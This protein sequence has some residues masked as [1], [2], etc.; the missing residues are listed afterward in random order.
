MKLK[1]ITLLAA[2]ASLAAACSPAPGS[3]EWCKGIETGA[4]KPTFEEAVA[5]G[6]KCAQY[7]IDKTFGPG[8]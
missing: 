5:H 7:M 1:T 3:E 6:D 4:V 8:Q 2:T